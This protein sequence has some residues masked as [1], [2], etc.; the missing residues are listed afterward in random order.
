MDP[1][2]KALI[3]R[4]T[5]RLE[6]MAKVKGAVEQLETQMKKLPASI[7]EKMAT[8]R[9]VSYDELGRYR[10]VFSDESQARCFGLFVLAHV[11]GS[12]KAQDALAGEMK[13]IYER[14]MG[15]TTATGSGTVPIEFSNRVERLVQAFG[16]F[17]AN[18]FPMP[19][20]SDQLTFQRRVSGI[21]VFKTGRNIA[22]TASEMGFATVNLNADEWNGL[23]LYPK[24]MG[25]D[26]AASIGEMVAMELAQAFAETIDACGFIGNGTPTYLDVVGITTR[27]LSINTVAP[28]AAGGLVLGT[29][30]AWSELIEADFLKLCG[31]L[32]QY[33]GA[34]NKWYASNAFIWQVMHR[35][36]L[37]KGGVTRAEFAGEQKLMFLGYP[38]EVVQS[39]A[40]AQANS[41]VP[42]LF[43]DLR[44]S[45]THGKR[46]ELTIEESRDV[47]FIERQVAVLGTQRH[48]ISN[49][50]LG[51]ATHAGPV[52]GLLTAAS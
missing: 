32:P 24:S 43:G 14:A 23:V 3:Q 31:Q 20:T 50:S 44:L 39:M 28:D 11:G 1:E 25:E 15:D 2:T 29:G 7:E 38:I 27:L 26:A 34:M 47:K 40:T 10:G 22:T 48:A 6:D 12:Q 4:M 41:Q 8:I 16:V 46:K 37:A 18:A 5:E 19:M 9:A 42:C 13:S 33:R 51:D 17:A 35:V 45:S 21:T 52:V 36:T 49:H 30:N